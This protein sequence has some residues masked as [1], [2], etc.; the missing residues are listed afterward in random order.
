MRWRTWIRWCISTVKF[1]VLINGSPAG[2]FHSSRGLRQG[3]PLSP[4]LFVFVMEGLSR[5]TSALVSNGFVDGIL[6]G[7][8]DRG[9][10]NI[11][12]LLFADDTLIFC[13]PDRNQIQVLKALLLCFEAVSGLKVNLN[14]SE[15]VSIGERMGG[16]SSTY[17]IA[18]GYRF[19]DQILEGCLVYQLY[20]T[21]QFSYTF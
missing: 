15:M 11:S 19:K 3:D 1:S 16:F 13:K 14:K 4:L 2:F 21:R 5:M 10:I 20:S 18:I 8:P 7:T 12:H 17:K 6:L 9:I